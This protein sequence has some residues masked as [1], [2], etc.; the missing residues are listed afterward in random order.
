MKYLLYFPKI[1]VILVLL[2]P[3]SMDISSKIPYFNGRTGLDL[4][5][6]CVNEGIL[7]FLCVKPLAGLVVDV[8]KDADSTKLFGKNNHSKIENQVV[9]NM[10]VRPFM[11]RAFNQTYYYLFNKSY[12][13]SKNIIIGKNRNLFE[14]PYIDKYCNLSRSN[15]ESKFL[16]D[17]IADLVKINKYYQQR[18]KQF[19]YFISPSK[20]SY[21]PEDIPYSFGCGISPVRPD[22]NLAINKL[23]NS[24]ILFVDGSKL[25]LDMKGKYP[26]EMFPRGGT[27]WNML[28]T[29]IASSTIISSL[30]SSMGFDLPDLNFKYKVDHNPEGSDSDLMV[31]LNLL[32]PEYNYNVPHMEYDNKLKESDHQLSM[33]I[34]G[35]SFMNNLY[36]VFKRYPIINKLDYLNYFKI[37]HLSHPVQ[38]NFV[39]D[40]NDKT[41]YDCIYSA[42]IILLEE[43]EEHLNSNHM[44]LLKEKLEIN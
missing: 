9:N 39:V 26:V 16:D 36:E 28:A 30:R 22:Y 21:Y 41:S 40:I 37:G 31:L 19:I 33:L 15:I 25:M 20:A 44:K 12:M 8:D 23:K 18:G 13:Y 10:L 2:L 17:W 4:E 32:A 6:P 5:Q 29:S 43:N 38:G 35:G 1:I 3:I 7:S 34:I 27:H 14:I 24:G 11:V 42:N